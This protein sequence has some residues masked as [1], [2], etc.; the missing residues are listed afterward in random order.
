MAGVEP[1]GGEESSRK[2]KLTDDEL[3]IVW[4]KLDTAAMA[5]ATRLALKLLLVTGQRRGEVTFAQK[6]HFDLP[7]SLWSIP[8]ELQKTEGSR[9]YPTEPH[10]VP[11]SKLATDLVTELFTLAGESPWLLPSQYSKKN[12]DA[13]Y[14]ERALTRAVRENQAHFGIPEWTP[15]DLRRTCRTGLSHLKVEPHIAERIL[16]H[17]QGRISETYDRFE[18]LGEKRDVLEKWATHLE[19]ILSVQGVG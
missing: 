6:H 2:R 19:E 11:L 12:A 18:Y 3:R 9:K 4:T 13:P 10:L 14:S 15:H 16:N 1:P 5:P 8:P 17:A 7:A